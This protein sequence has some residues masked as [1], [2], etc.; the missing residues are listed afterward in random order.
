MSQG[1]FDPRN[2]DQT[3]IAVDSMILDN[4]DAITKRVRESKTMHDIQSEKLSE[5][6]KQN[7]AMSIEMD[8]MAEIIRKT[9]GEKIA[10]K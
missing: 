5:L 6:D 2:A 9:T 7:K 4:K 3:L 10:G 1:A 8:Q